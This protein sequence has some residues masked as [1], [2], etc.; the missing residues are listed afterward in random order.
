M[1]D[2]HAFT[3]PTKRRAGRP[4]KSESAKKRRKRATDAKSHRSR[5][6]IGTEIDRWNAFKEQLGLKSNAETAKLFLDR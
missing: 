6:N 4:Q 1:A 2:K 5:I 3:S